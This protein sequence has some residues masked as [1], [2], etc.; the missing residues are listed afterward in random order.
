M[1]PETVP[2][3]ILFENRGR[4]IGYRI[5]RSLRGSIEISMPE[6]TNDL[7]VLRADLADEL[8]EFGLYRKEALAMIQTW[9]DSWFEEGMVV[10]HRSANNG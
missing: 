10:L 5:A 4:K 7:E 9:L 2:L 1:S 8:V 3:V 6:L